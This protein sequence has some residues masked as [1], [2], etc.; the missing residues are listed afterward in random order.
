MTRFLDRRYNER[1]P[2]PLD[3]RSSGPLNKPGERRLDA[4]A[5]NQ[6][7]AELLAGIKANTD[8]D[9]LL[10]S[11][12]INFVARNVTIAQAT[13]P[14]FG[15]TNPATLVIPPNQAPRG[16]V[17]VNP[18]E[19]SAF[20]PYVQLIPTMLTVAPGVVTGN[21]FRVATIDT[22]RVFMNVT[23]NTNNDQIIVNAQTQNPFATLP[24]SLWVTSQADIFNSPNP[25]PL[26]DYYADIGPLGVDVNFRVQTNSLA[27]GDAFEV[28]GVFKGS[29]SGLLSSTIYLG[30]QDV[31]PTFGFPL[32][33]NQY[34]YRYLRENTALYAI[35]ATKH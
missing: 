3:V 15:Q 22:V 17:L 28:D 27:V 25:T 14:L 35:T 12:G 5:Q 4:E 33:A 18:A 26:G 32:L 20:Q 8:I 13:G 6:Q 19:L 2:T 11:I 7:I 29:S 31:N 23:Q 1:E 10:Q 9:V 21:P 24:T 30:T 16:Y 34:Q